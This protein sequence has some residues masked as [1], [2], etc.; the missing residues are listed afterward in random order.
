LVPAGATSYPA[1]VFQAKTAAAMYHR[2]IP[3]TD[4]TS[5][6]AATSTTATPDKAVVL[7]LE[8]GWTV[9]LLYGVPS[10]LRTPQNARRPA[11]NALALARQ[12]ERLP[13][14][15][16][17]VPHK[18]V[19]LERARLV[20]LLKQ[21]KALKTPLSTPQPSIPRISAENEKARH[22]LLQVFHFGMLRYLTSLGREV[23]LAY[24]LGRS[25]RD[26]ANPP[27]RR[28]EVDLN[29]DTAAATP[30]ELEMAI[31]KQLNPR[32]LARLQGWLATLQSS[33]P[34]SSASI[35]SASMEQWSELVGVLF[36][37]DSQPERE[38]E[39]EYDAKRH[40]RSSKHDIAIM[41]DALLF[42]GDAWLN[43]LIG[44]KSSTG[45]LTP[46]S[47][48]AAGEAALSRTVRLIRRILAHYWFALVIVVFALAGI[49]VFALRD[50]HGATQFWTQVVAVAGT[51]GVTAKGIAS[52]V[53]TLGKEMESPIYA[54]AKIDAAAWSITTFPTTLT[55]SKR[56]LHRLRKSTAD[57]SRAVMLALQN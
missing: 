39:H 17:L 12:R 47:Q 41:H 5:T 18:R 7:A 35:V 25:L 36:R 33:L 55:L 26:T 50:L 24:E 28:G 6:A 43:L 38:Y 46:E 57:K 51:F 13:T 19:E 31:S 9:A 11:N 23:G 56:E 32:R 53:V 45:L 30:D 42:Q 27:T 20:N 1:L 54:S 48:V 29:T 34:D 52:G 16:E 14:E 10:H 8:I 2:K 37:T 22:S 44:A 3:S 49:I 15:H 21:M 40:A 4:T